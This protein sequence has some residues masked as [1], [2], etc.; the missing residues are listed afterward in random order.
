MRVYSGSAK[1]NIPPFI[2]QIPRSAPPVAPAAMLNQPPP[3]PKSQALLRKY[4]PALC[5]KLTPDWMLFAMVA[6]YWLKFMSTMQTSSCVYPIHRGVR[7]AR[8]A[9]RILGYFLI[10][11]FQMEEI[12]ESLVFKGVAERLTLGITRILG[13]YSVFFALKPAYRLTS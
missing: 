10:G 9:P 13:M 4:S 2:Q 1:T 5:C 3:L 7:T 12:K 6:F 11:V 8:D